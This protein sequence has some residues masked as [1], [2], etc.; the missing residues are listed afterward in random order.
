MDKKTRSTNMLPPRVQSQIEQYTQ[1]KVKGW[2]KI[3]MQME[4]K[5]AVGSSTYI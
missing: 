4:K 3:F 2:K 1:T 5:K